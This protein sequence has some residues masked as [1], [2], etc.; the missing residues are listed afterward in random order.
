[1]RTHAGGETYEPRSRAVFAPPVCAMQSQSLVK[2]DNPALVGGGKA[3]GSKGKKPPPAPGGKALPPVDSKLTQTEDI[4]N[5][6][7]PPRW[8][9]ACSHARCGP[10]TPCPRPPA[11]AVSVAR[12]ARAFLQLLVW[13]GLQLLA[14]CRRL[15]G[16]RWLRVA[17]PPPGRRL[18]GWA[19]PPLCPARV[20]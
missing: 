3:K 5:S 7:L 2:Y 14:S 12:G 13:D 11:R 4:L 1:M 8:G 17:V 15:Q 9:H 6:I 19:L 16:R 10:P 18:R 20:L